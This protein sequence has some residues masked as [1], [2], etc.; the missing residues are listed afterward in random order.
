MRLILLIFFAAFASFVYGQDKSYDYCYQNDKGICV[1]SVGDKAEQVIIKKGSDA[2]ISP[3][4]KKVAYTTYSPNGDRT[5]A[6]IDLNT[7]KT[8]PLHPGHHRVPGR[9]VLTAFQP[10]R[11]C[12]FVKLWWRVRRADRDEYQRQSGLHRHQERRLRWTLQR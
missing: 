2:R 7:K 3:D 8:S 11:T 4:G 1:Y 5:I 10:I 6:V 9:S 12:S